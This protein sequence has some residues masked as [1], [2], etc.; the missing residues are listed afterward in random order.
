MIEQSKPSRRNEIAAMSFTLML[1]CGAEPT[2]TENM[3]ELSEVE[4]DVSVDV[5]D[6]E[7]SDEALAAEDGA[8]VLK[9]TFPANSGC[10]SSQRSTVRADEALADLY[11]NAI[12]AVEPSMKFFPT[13]ESEQIFANHFG[14]AN[15]ANLN[16]V[17][18]VYQLINDNLVNTTYLCRTEDH[19]DCTTIGVRAR[20]TF[21]GTTT[22][23]C[24]LYFEQTE[25]GRAQT[26]I[27]ELSHQNR[28]APDGEGAIDM[29]GAS[30]DN[31]HMYSIYAPKCFEDTC[32]PI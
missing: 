3:D 4:P 21:T 1:A 13:P 2:A 12:A 8:S 18:G 14:P 19:P 5:V 30:I 17:F 9:A 15:L 31:A 7:A 29:V 25:R 27:H 24:P 23:L 11:L 28:N 20:T 22:F 26:I 6:V 16:F 32:F 10:T